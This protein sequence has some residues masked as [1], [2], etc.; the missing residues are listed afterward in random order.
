MGGTVELREPTVDFD[1]GIGE[2]RGG[3]VN[4]GRVLVISRNLLVYSQSLTV[5]FRDS[6]VACWIRGRS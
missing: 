3:L 2:L 6:S 5:E 1:G 4:S